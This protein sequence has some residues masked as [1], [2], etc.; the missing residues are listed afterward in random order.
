MQRKGAPPSTCKIARAQCM[1]DDIGTPK[2]RMMGL[3][4]SID[5]TNINLGRH[6]FKN[7]SK[8]ALYVRSCVRTSES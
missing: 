4:K 1:L 6:I 7:V 8:E 5:L 2:L 3:H